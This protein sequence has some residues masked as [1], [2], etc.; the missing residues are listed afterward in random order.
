MWRG[1]QVVIIL[2]AEVSCSSCDVVV[3]TVLTVLTSGP[4]PSAAWR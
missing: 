1:F 4:A 2:V 3:L